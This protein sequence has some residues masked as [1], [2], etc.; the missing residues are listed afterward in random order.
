MCRK[1][2]MTTTNDT[3]KGMVSVIVPNYNH[4]GFLRERIDS[5][6]GQTY[7]DIELILLDDCS[8]DNSWEVIENYRNEPRVSHVVLNEQ[9]SGSTFAQW[10]RGLALARGEYVWIA[11]SDDFATPDFLA[12][13]VPHLEA[14]PEAALAFAGS[15]MVDALG[16]NIPH[17]DWDRYRPGQP[18]VEV[19]TGRELMVR[20]LLWT[21]NVYNASQAVF[22]RSM[23][24][25][26][27]DCQL[28]MRYCGDWLFWVNLATRGGAV[29]V[30]RKLNRFRQHTAKVSPGAS[31]S[32]IYFIEGLPVMV[33]VADYLDL[34]RWQRAML[35]G[36]TWK[37]LGKFPQILATHRDEIMANLDR[38][39]PG[40]SGC[41]HRLIT[42]YEAD[43]Y[44]N[45][46]HLQPK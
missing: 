40:A 17:M 14:N 32:G 39:S 33:R 10:K 25:A 22:R 15:L 28:R 24:P 30:R 37:R 9:N 34:G 27:E 4:A 26:I 46:T 23:A 7:G 19:Y 42:L 21:A 38:L 6:L 36:R 18:E 41:K 43:K 44:L 45:F 29:E 13:L 3:I 8:T 35:A 11:E 31:K 5:V 12:T 2:A 1:Y 20:K 16:N